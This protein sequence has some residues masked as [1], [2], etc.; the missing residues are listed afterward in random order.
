MSFD[1]TT[2]EDIFYEADSFEVAEMLSSEELVLITGYVGIGTFPWSGIM[3]DDATGNR[4]FLAFNHDHSSAPNS[5]ILLDIT[6]Q[7]R[8]R[9]SR[10]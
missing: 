4:Y 5:F 7:L 1:E 8:H 9:E 10:E 2:N 3:F 6:A